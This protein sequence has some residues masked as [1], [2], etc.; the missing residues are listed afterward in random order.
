MTGTFLRLAVRNVRRNRSRTA[1]TLAAIGFGVLMTIFLGAISQGFTNLFTDDAMKDRTGA[2]QVHRKG[3]FEAKA[4]NPLDFDMESGGAM[5]KRI[6]AVP[7]VIDVA[8]RLVFQALING[9]GASSVVIVTGVDPVAEYRVLPWV[10]GDIMG[11]R[12]TAG[13]ASG[14]VL[15]LD[16]GDALSVVDHRQKKVGSKVLDDPLPKAGGTATLSAT[17]KGGRQNALDVDIV[18]LIRGGTPYDAKR[19]GYV[20]LAFAQ[21]LLDMKDRANE[22][23]VAVTGREDVPIVK[24]RLQAALGPDYDIRDWRQLRPFVGDIIDVQRKVLVFVCFVFLVI[25][26]FG[27][28]NTMLMSVLERTREI[29]TM[30]A[31]GVRRIHVTV[32]F[33]LEGATLALLG[34]FAGAVGGVALVAAVAKAGGVVITPQGSGSIRSLVPEAPSQ[35]IV[36]AIV[37]A[38]LGSLAAAA[39]PAWRASRLRPVE[40]LRSV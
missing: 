35:L 40:A 8:P 25:A 20:P 15:G 32:L 38:T 36:I 24:A 12:V 21:D 34:G 10:P 37:A 14:A 3:Y 26:V 30:M 31:F 11:T 13:A 27:V 2:L 23:L 17:R 22:Y 29:G 9:P 19:T 18:G 7:G 1:L 28:I 4:A 16:L 33:L 5:E 6:L 39:Y